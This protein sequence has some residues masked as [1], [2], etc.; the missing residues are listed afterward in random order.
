MKKRIPLLTSTATLLLLICS[1]ASAGA[2]TLSLSGL[3]STSTVSSN[4]DVIINATNN[5]AATWT[6]KRATMGNL[7][8]GALPLILPGATNTIPA[9]VSNTAN[10]FMPFPIR[11]PVNLIFEGDSLTQEAGSGTD[12]PH[13]PPYSTYPLYLRGI[14]TNYFASWT[15]YGAGFAVLGT[16]TGRQATVLA[17]LPAGTNNLEFLWI[18]AND[19]QPAGGAITNAVTWLATFETYCSNIQSAGINLAVFTVEDRWPLSTGDPVRQAFRNA[20][21]TGIRAS[22]FHDYLVDMDLAN[23]D[24]NP[25]N[26]WRTY[27]G[28]HP[29]TNGAIWQAQYVQYCLGEAA[30]IGPKLNPN[31]RSTNATATTTT[32]LTTNLAYNNL[33]LCFTNGLLTSILLPDS[34]VTNFVARAG[35]T[36]T[37]DITAVSNLVVAAKAHGWWTNCD[38]IYPFVGGSSNS[39]AQNLKGTNYAITWAGTVW[40]TNGVT[41]DGTTGYGST[42]F[43]PS[44][45]NNTI[46]QIASNHLFCYV[47]TT[48]AAPGGSEDGWIGAYDAASGLFLTAKPGGCQARMNSVT[49][50]GSG[51]FYAGPIIAVRTNVYSTNGFVSHF[52]TKAGHDADTY[53]NTMT[54]GDDV[55]G[56]VNTN[57]IVLAIRSHIDGSLLWQAN[58]PLIGVSIGGGMSYTAWTLLREDWRTF[59]S[60]LSR[61]P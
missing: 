59:E 46:Y 36:N 60:A 19:F 22:Q 15:N 32:G 49:G 14:W 4:D 29:N 54:L 3:P 7:I 58:G 6:T 48:N 41:G 23:P 2:A 47:G 42:G 20:I 12:N 56:T 26:N 25:T 21:N 16:V 55:S 43:N 27:D 57:L 50:T 10:S 24:M 37:T 61:N 44:V 8:A 40:F 45:T 52:E 31:A 9:V 28:T 5:G 39:T 18:G 17:N 33:Y 35:L 34:D 38:V 1:L 30:K 53:F 13:V 11:T 51:S